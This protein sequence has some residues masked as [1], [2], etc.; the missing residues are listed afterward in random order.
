MTQQAVWFLVWAATKP[1]RT[2]KV[3]DRRSVNEIYSKTAFVM[4]VDG[5]VGRQVD[6]Y[7]RELP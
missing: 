7:V 2:D 1:G 6:I 4:W 5:L 3:R